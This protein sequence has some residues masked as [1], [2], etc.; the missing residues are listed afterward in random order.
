MWWVDQMVKQ[1]DGSY[2]APEAVRQTIREMAVEYFDLISAL[3]GK[4]SRVVAQATIRT[5]DELAVKYFV[6]EL[7][8]IILTDKSPQVSVLVTGTQGVA[9]VRGFSSDGLTAFF[10]FRTKN[11]KYDVYDTTNWDVVSRGSSPSDLDEIWGIRFDLT[12]G[13]WKMERLVGQFPR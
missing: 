6:G 11:A 3:N 13:R 1:A 8:R 4:D 5:E 9:D 10:T 12:D 2:M 7:R